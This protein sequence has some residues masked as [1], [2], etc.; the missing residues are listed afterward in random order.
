MSAS[1]GDPQPVFDLIV[2]RARE[3]CNGGRGLVRIRRRTGPLERRMSRHRPGSTR[4]LRSDFPRPPDRTSHR[5]AGRSWTA[6]SSISGTWTPS[7]AIAGGARTR[8]AGRDRGD[9]ADARRQ[10]DRR[11]LAAIAGTRRLLRQ[12]DRAAEDLRRAGGDRDQQRRDVSRVAD[13]H[14]RPSGIAGIPDRDQRRAEGHQPL[15]LR[16]ATRAG[17]GGRDRRPALR[18]RSGRDLPPRGR[19]VCG[20][21]RILGFHRNTRLHRE[22]WE[23]CHSTQTRRLSRARA[24]RERPPVHIHDVAAVPGYPDASIRLGKQ[25]TSLGVPLL[26]EGEAIGVIVSRASGS[27]RSPTG[28][29]SLSAPS[30]IRR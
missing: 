24:V 10:R 29:S 1:P 3:L 9:P 14:G 20:W 21:W 8:R 5:R 16:S 15:D 18:C 2:R 30:P 25:R 28:R 7:R 13:P 6:R 26:R 19:V 23:R 11:H 17:Y 27:S 12:P 4:Q 22:H